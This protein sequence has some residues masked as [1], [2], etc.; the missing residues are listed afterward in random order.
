MAA[1]AVIGSRNP[2]AIKAAIVKQYGENHYEFSSNVWF[3]TD[4][5]T[6]KDILDKLGLTGGKIGAQA[7]VLRVD[8][9]AGFGPAPAWAW[10][11]KNSDAAIHG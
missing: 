1:F 9:Y 2:D 5:G 8:A 3:V 11:Q 10:L 7:V 4:A 6:T